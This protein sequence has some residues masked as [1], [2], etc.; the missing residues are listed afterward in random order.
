MK[1]TFS[2]I[3]SIFVLPVIYYTIFKSLRSL[4]VETRKEQLLGYLEKKG[5]VQE[6]SNWV[7]GLMYRFSNIYMNQVRQVITFHAPAISTFKIA[8]CLLLSFICNKMGDITV[9]AIVIL[10]AALSPLLFLKSSDNQQ[11]SS[12]N[13]S[14]EEANKD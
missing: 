9:F 12:T 10:I 5:E 3:G 4:S 13:T 11:T 2:Q 14:N 6:K 8:S 1:F 7:F